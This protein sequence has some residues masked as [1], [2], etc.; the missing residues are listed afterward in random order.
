M[1]HEIFEGRLYPE[2]GLSVHHWWTVARGVEVQFA[3]ESVL[4]DDAEILMYAGIHTITNSF[5]R[6]DFYGPNS[7]VKSGRKIQLRD[8]QK[9]HKVSSRG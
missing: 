3:R 6:T 9:P 4:S 7:C 5:K 1:I 2:A 8:M